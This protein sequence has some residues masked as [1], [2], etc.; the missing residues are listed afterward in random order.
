MRKG[1][2][3]VLAVLLLAGS[4]FLTKYLIDNK[5]KPKPRF[6]KIVKTVFTET[7][8]NKKIPILIT[9]NGNLEAKNKIEIYSEV[10]GILIQTSKDFK[11]GTYFQKGETIIKINSDEFYANLQA[12]KSNL[13][14]ALTAIMPDIRLDYSEEYNKWVSYIQ[15]FDINKPIKKLPLSTTDK[16][17]F[18][19]SG[20]GILTSYFNVKNL[21][22]KFAKYTLQAPFKGVLTESL[23]NPGSLIRPGQKLGEFID[24]S[25]Y[26]VSVSVKSEYR[27]L[28]K[29][30]KK[31]T[32]QNLETT[33]NWIGKVVR[34]N[35]KVDAATQTIKAFIQV[36]GND[37]KEG[38]Y[39]EVVLE[40]KSEDNAYEIPRKLLIDNSKLYVVKD[41]VLDLIDVTI[42]FENKNTVVVKDLPNGIQLLSKLVPGAHTGMLVKIY[43]EKTVE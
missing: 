40:A 1:I 33:K 41:T 28:L 14:N 10:Q 25:V 32:L 11:P 38:Q 12:Q 29:V 17:K 37:L 20:R 22:V 27:N 15:N 7:V 8:E 43:N 13:L 35:G 19:I 31:V 5:Q 30:G 4:F 42:A 23:V 3:I 18:F 26:E 36:N 2:S 24:P 21:E 9:A 34:I 16:E 6:D 39:L